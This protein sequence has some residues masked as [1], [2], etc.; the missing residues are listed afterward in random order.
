V[1]PDSDGLGAH[2]AGASPFANTA[3]RGPLGKGDLQRSRR[4]IGLSTVVLTR[5]AKAVP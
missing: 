4:G 3:A 2:G 1:T 5:V